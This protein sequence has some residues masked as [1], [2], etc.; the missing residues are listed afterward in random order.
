MV[1]S[2]LVECLSANMACAASAVLFRLAFWLVFCLCVFWL[3]FVLCF[4]QFETKVH[5]TQQRA[6]LF[7]LL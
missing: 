7:H 6:L 3:V 1:A 4:L 5:E 2:C